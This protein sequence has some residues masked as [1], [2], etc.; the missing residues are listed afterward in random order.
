MMYGA[1]GDGVTDDTAAVKA[2]I[3]ANS[4]VLLDRRYAV[5]TGVGGYILAASDLAGKTIAGIDRKNAGLIT[6]SNLIVIAPGTDCT[7]RNFRITGTHAGSIQIGV[8]LENGVRDV[9]CEG[10]WFDDLAIGSYASGT[11]FGIVGPSNKFHGCHY[12]AASTA[13]GVGHKAALQ[14]EYTRHVGC[15]FSGL[16]VGIRIGA[17]NVDVLGCTFGGNDTCVE[18]LGNDG[19]TVTNDGHGLFA[20]NRL[21]HSTHLLVQTG[22]LVNG[23]YFSRNYWNAGDFAFAAGA[24]RI[25]FLGDILDTITGVSYGGTSAT[26]AQVTWID[27]DQTAKYIGP[28]SIGVS[29]NVESGDRT[30]VTYGWAASTDT[31]TG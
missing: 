6:T 22:A 10:L 16:S 1:A 9:L 21:V 29:P 19:S 2:A 18:L 4:H 30:N 13:A 24:K 3:A 27:V 15:D 17:G 7:L 25:K 11:S 31:R 12:T 23:H 8:S 14:G 5:N 20:D 28:E 26:A